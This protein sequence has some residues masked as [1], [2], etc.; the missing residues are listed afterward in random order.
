MQSNVD[1]LCL[2]GTLG[3]SQERQ[4]NFAFTSKLRAPQSKDKAKGRI[5]IQRICAPFAPSATQK[6]VEQ[7]KEVG[8]EKVYCNSNFASI[9]VFAE[10]GNDFV[11]SK[12]L[13]SIEIA[14][15][16]SGERLFT[17]AMIKGENAVIKDMGMPNCVKT[18][19]H[20]TNKIE[21]ASIIM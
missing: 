5:N 18:V 2:T 4:G 1:E 11:C 19:S 12:L 15:D 14:E 13:P 3:V 21:I 8:K 17:S 6:L 10:T 9:T 16:V 20:P 7:I